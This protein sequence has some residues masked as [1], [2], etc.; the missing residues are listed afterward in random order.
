MIWKNR[1]SVHGLP[2]RSKNLDT[3]LETDRGQ[4]QDIWIRKFM[5]EHFRERT[6]AR[7][8]ELEILAAFTARFC[9][10]ECEWTR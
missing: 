1:A 5:T 7:K 6:L 10:K 8:Q 9:S 4:I 3:A 2:A